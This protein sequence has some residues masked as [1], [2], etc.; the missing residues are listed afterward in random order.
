M[1]GAWAYDVFLFGKVLVSLSVSFC[2]ILHD[3]NVLMVCCV[4]FCSR[5]LVGL[6]ALGFSMVS[7][8]AKALRTI[9]F[10][11]SC[12]LFHSSELLIKATHLIA[13]LT[14]LPVCSIVF[15]PIN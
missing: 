8:P 15:V 9:H 5:L 7:L 10:M 13:S 6:S 12:W 11:C 1:A 3:L 14:L 4:P 2:Q